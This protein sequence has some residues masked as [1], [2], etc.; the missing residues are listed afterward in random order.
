MSMDAN[1]VIRHHNVDLYFRVDTRPPASFGLPTV[2]TYRMRYILLAYGYDTYGRALSSGAVAGLGE[3]DMS[4]NQIRV[5]HM[6]SLISYVPG[7]TDGIIPPFEVTYT[8]S[9]VLDEGI[10]F[11]AVFDIKNLT[12]FRF[13]VKVVNNL[14]FA[15]G[16]VVQVA[17][18][19]GWVHLAP[20]QTKYL[21]GGVSVSDISR[22]ENWGAYRLHPQTQYY[23]WGTNWT[24]GYAYGESDISMKDGLLSVMFKAFLTAPN[25][26]DTLPPNFPALMAA[27]TV[28]L[29]RDPTL[30]QIKRYASD[31]HYGYESEFGL[32]YPDQL[33]IA[34]ISRSISKPTYQPLLDPA[35]F[36]D[37]AVSPWPRRVNPGADTTA[38][39][40]NAE[41]LMWNGTAFVWT[42]VTDELI[43]LTREMMQ[44]VAAVLGIT[45]YVVIDGDDMRW[46][47]PD[48][49]QPFDEGL[50]SY[51]LWVGRFYTRGGSVIDDGAMRA[52]FQAVIDEN[53]A[54]WI[55]Y[56]NI[57]VHPSVWFGAFV[58]SILYDYGECMVG[59]DGS[60]VEVSGFGDLGSVS[61]R[62]LYKIRPEFQ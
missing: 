12:T 51:G 45:E 36:L 3:L 4:S 14:D 52:V 59:P 15:V 61:T 23:G 35:T 55:N 60:M 16:L 25:N 22:V 19:H 58:G 21:A 26:P 9:P 8:K 13:V 1:G 24:V 7:V 27:P 50:V 39:R 11:D 37:R 41:K 42:P 18:W 33:A 62:F 5:S 34:R 47:F 28:G 30:P 10:E 40:C 32:Y 17:G 29:G 6:P 2:G 48:T 20:G 44:E 57:V 54:S 46:M 43:Y 56:R 53:A 49:S 31:A 38:I